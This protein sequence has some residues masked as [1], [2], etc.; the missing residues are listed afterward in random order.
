MCDVLKCDWQ[1]MMS[2]EVLATIMVT[3]ILSYE[4]EEFFPRKM[5]TVT[6]VQYPYL[7]AHASTHTKAIQLRRNGLFQIFQL[8]FSTYSS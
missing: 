2:M 8:I 4:L 3:V 1:I 7:Q 6:C 5:I